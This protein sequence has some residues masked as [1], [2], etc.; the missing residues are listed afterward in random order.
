MHTEVYKSQVYLKL[1]HGTLCIV[2]SV[3][4]CFLFCLPYKTASW[5]ASQKVATSW[6]PKHSWLHRFYMDKT[7]DN[8]DL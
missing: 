1:A 6:L 2:S 3:H 8:N 5:P 7:Y 4:G